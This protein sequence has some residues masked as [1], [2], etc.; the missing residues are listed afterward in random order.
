MVKNT[1]QEYRSKA[2]KSQDTKYIFFKPECFEYRI[3]DL[4]IKIQG[5]YNG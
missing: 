1:G 2:I 5:S 3:Q 4:D